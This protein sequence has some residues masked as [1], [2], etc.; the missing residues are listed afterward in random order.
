MVVIR[1]NTEFLNRTF[2][3]DFIHRLQRYASVIG[4]SVE[5]DDGTVKVEFN[6]DRPDLYSFYSLNRSMEIF[7]STSIP[8]IIDLHESDFEVHIEK[9]AMSIRP[10]FLSLLATG[11]ALGEKL[12]RIIEY[13]E[14]LHGT[15]G[16]ERQSA[17]IGIHS[18]SNA[19]TSVSYSLKESRSVSIKTFDGDFDGTAFDLI[20]THPLGK[21]YISLLPSADRVNVIED[22]DGNVMSIPP[23]SNSFSTRLAENS[24]RLFVDIEGTDRVAV[25]HVFFLMA[26]ELQ[27]MGYSISIPRHHGIDKKIIPEL[28]SENGREIKFSYDD[29]LKVLGFE[30]SE[31]SISNSLR[32]MGY[33]ATPSHNGYVVTIPGNRVDVMGAVDVIED[34]AKGMGY[35]QIPFTP[36]MPQTHGIAHH[37]DYVIETAS[38][39]LIGSGY[40]EVKSFVVGSQLPFSF[41]TY[42]GDVTLFNP[43]S[44]DF[45]VVRDRLYVN[46]LE[47]IKQNRRRPMP[48]KIFEIGDIIEY[49]NQ[50]THLCFMIHDTK[51]PFSA[52][53]QVLEY[54]VGR[55]TPSRPVI[56]RS[57]EDGL[58]SG[59]C[60]SIYLDGK[61]IGFIGEMHPALLELFAVT[62]PISLGEIDISAL[63]Q[64][65]Q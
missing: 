26:Y 58:I 6:P 54:L 55:F 60:G 31:E 18:I 12:P 10:Y 20:S 48:Q 29:I 50:K 7:D 41:L 25:F 1:D 15:I 16:R 40:Q 63:L 62:D 11:S 43:K 32:K 39:I 42:R 52:V 64:T 46:M 61:N 3:N 17:S 5:I 14:R 28:R 30:S 44:S 13:Q 22:A 36:I 49:G 38:H 56:T 8:G 21:K 19:C 37:D 9:N 59:R 27:A 34:I 35:D 57:D 2:G 47:I 51:A 33:V 4:F 53:K 45:S 24:T 65:S 23:I